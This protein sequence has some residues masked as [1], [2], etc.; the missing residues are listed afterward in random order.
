[1]RERKFVK[2]RVDMYEDTKF[3]II[4]KMEKRDLIQYVWTRIVT[5]A[6]KV[7]LAGDLYLSKSIPYTLETLAIEFN[8]DV[9]DIKLA[10]NA[11][12]NLEMIELVQGKIYKVKNFAK[13]QNIKVKEK[14]D[15]EDSKLNVESNL[16]ERNVKSGIDIEKQPNEAK[17]I[18]LSRNEEQNLFDSREGM[19]GNQSNAGKLKNSEIVNNEKNSTIS[20]IIEINKE[21]KDNPNENEMKSDT[22]VTL[23][24]KKSKK[25]TQDIS[26]FDE[27]CVTDDRDGIIEIPEGQEKITL[28]KGEEIL[29]TF[30]M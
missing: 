12:I 11:F 3:K 25:A 27:V 29:M 17:N 8:R 10:I 26:C 16:E 21:I 23:K 20:N 22:Q 13:H 15:L 6:G 24:R 4:D 28:R 2:L 7:N 18:D 14:A 1:M 5:L 19:P 9:E 30:T